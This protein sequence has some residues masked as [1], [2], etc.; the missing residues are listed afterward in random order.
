[1]EFGARALGNRSILA[2][3]SDARVV[4]RINRAIKNRDFWMPSTPSLLA[5]DA[6]RYAVNPK[7]IAA[8]YM[9][10]TFDST[11]AAR[12]DLAATLHPQDH[13][14]RPQVVER[15]WNPEYHAVLSRFKELTGIGGVLNTS[16]NLHG[17]PNVGSPDDALRTL[18]ASGLRHLALGPFLVSKRPVPVDVPATVGA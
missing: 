11:E 13:T 1:M 18:A 8:P 12:R 6:D 2:N 10:L 7:R 16:F 5:E 14:L 4:Q 15:S 9:T 17:E 3:P